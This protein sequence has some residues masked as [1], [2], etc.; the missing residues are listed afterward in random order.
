MSLKDLE[1]KPVYYSDEISILTEFYIPVLKEAKCYDRIAGY[2]CSNSLSLAA[3]GIAG[4]IKNG[5]K[6]RLIA[7][8]V[9]TEQDQEAI[10]EAIKNKEDIIISEFDKIEDELQRDHVKMLGWMIKSKLL[11]IKI[12][13]VNRGLEHQKIGILRDS[14]GNF[15][16]FSGSEN[17][18]VGGWLNNDEQFH[19]FCSWKL[20]DLNHLEPDIERFN[21]LWENKGKKVKVYE[22]SEAFKKGIVKKAPKDEEEFIRLTEEL[23]EALMDRQ[24]TYQNSEKKPQK[25]INLRDYQ[26]KAIGEWVKNNYK[27]IFKMATGTGKTF[28]AIAAINEFLKTKN[29]CLVVIVAPTQLLVNQWVENL[30]Y[31][32]YLDIIKV[33]QQKNIWL[34][35]LRSSLLKM[36]LN[37]SNYVFAVATYNS[38]CKDDFISTIKRNQE[39]SI[40][41]CD[42][43][44]HAWAPKTRRGLLHKFRYRLGLSA[45]PEIYMDEEGTEELIQY[46][47]GICFEFEMKDAIP[48]YLTEY[49]YYAEIVELNEEESRKYEDFSIKI[50]RNIDNNNGKIDDKTF[51]LILQRSKILVNASAKWPAFEKILDNINEIKKTLVYCSDKQLPRVKKILRARKILAHQ[52]TYEENLELREEIIRLFNKD[53][54]QVIIAMKVLDEGIDVPG[55]ERAIILASS[56]NPVEFVQRRGRILRKSEGKEYSL[57]NDIIVFP[58]KTIPLNISKSELSAIKRELKRVEE[59]AGCSRN[60]LNVIKKISPYNFLVEGELKK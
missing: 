15:L 41:I 13:V 49:E 40:L 45:T 20:G 22:V 43:V 21:I 23:K 33:M 48:D 57:I 58:W 10:K 24:H 18:T 53:K 9:L 42:E 39:E 17:E 46:F 30:E 60:P 28:T 25:V 11:E 14:G 3:V 6:I 36:E 51:M 29:K 55:I 27:G 54:V 52:I 56:G 19:V 38:F 8:V 2:F 31:F 35:E 12:A 1:L 16:S 32:G 44:H 47:G 37:R 26:K 7:N 4:L 50:A 5:G 59:F 34:E